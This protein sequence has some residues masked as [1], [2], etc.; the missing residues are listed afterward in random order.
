MFWLAQLENDAPACRQLGLGLRP[1]TFGIRPDEDG[2]KRLW[3]QGR[4]RYFDVFFEIR[5]QRLTWAQLSFRG[6]VLTFEGKTR[7][8]RVDETDEMQTSSYALSASRTL[9]PLPSEIATR[10]TRI[11]MAMVAARHEDPF[12]AAFGRQLRSALADVYAAPGAQASA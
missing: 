2:I 6:L 10:F 9:R 8:L 12:F 11:A 3:F 4:E 1:I 5:E 7:A